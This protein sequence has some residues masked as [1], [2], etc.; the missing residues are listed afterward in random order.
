MQSERYSRYAPYL[1]TGQVAQDPPRKNMS[2]ESSD[3]W[4]E[5]RKLRNDMSFESSET[6]WAPRALRYDMSFESS[7]MTWAP[8]ALMGYELWK[9][10]KRYEL[11]KL[12]NDMSSESSDGI[13]ALKA[14]KRH[15]LWELYGIM[16]APRALRY[17][18]S[19]NSSNEYEL[20]ELCHPRCEL[21]KLTDR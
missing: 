21:R 1:P 9:A 11:R 10:L 6:A 2:S 18:T 16:R 14:L 20:R 3:R 15:E 7:E 13:W 19:S 5:L 4:Y 8:R 17:D 12:W